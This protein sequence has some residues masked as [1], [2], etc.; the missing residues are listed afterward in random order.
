MPNL[1]CVSPLKVIIDRKLTLK[2]A[3]GGASPGPPMDALLTSKFVKFIGSEV[4]RVN[5][6]YLIVIAN[7]THSRLSFA[8][9]S[10]NLLR[11]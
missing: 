5:R 11:T 2:R 9:E 3:E 7:S 10:R 4:E 8:T 1:A 6:R